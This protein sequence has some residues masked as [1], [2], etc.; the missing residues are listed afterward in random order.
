MR[1]VAVALSAILVATS[2]AEAKQ[3]AQGRQ[4]FFGEKR[5]DFWRD[6]SPGRTS[7]TDSA[8]GVTESIWAEP[9]RMPDGRYTIFLPP[10]PVL[11][12]LEKPTQENARRYLAWQAERMEKMRKAAA[13]LSE[14]HREKSSK[15]PIGEA[16]AGAPVTITY[17]KKPG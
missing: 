6:G 1:K 12:F 4:G 2:G 5:V 9:I 16:G 8:A 10:R 17:F 7:T 11:E 13:I 14:V 3:E 15:A